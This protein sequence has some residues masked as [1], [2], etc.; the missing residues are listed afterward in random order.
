MK[1]L[2][3]TGTNEVTYREE[4]TPEPAA[5]DAKIR[6]EA[7]GI[8]GS[9]MHAYHGEDA[10]RVPPLILGHEAAGVVVSGK[11]AGQQVVLNPLISCGICLD[12]Q[13]GRS[14]LC[15]DRRLIG[16]NYPGA[17][18]EF[19]T[20]PEKNLIALPEGMNPV[21]AA[22]TEPAATSLHA[23]HLAERALHRPIADGRSLVI[24]G[25]SV[26]LLAA[27]LL[28]S[29]GCSEIMLCDTNPLRRETAFQTGCCE[30]FDP[31]QDTEKIE[32]SFELVIDAV[33]M[34]TTRQMAVRAVKSGGVMLHIGLQQGS[35]D[36]DFR[37]I[38]L[39]EMTVIGTYTYTHTDLQAAL[40]SLYRGKLGDLAWVEERPL[41]EG[42]SAFFDL[43]IG[44]TAAPK[45]V[46]LPGE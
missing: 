22:L 15:A 13:S 8:C 38:T 16:M 46:L 20:I 37:K 18:A 23:L 5:G 44:S 11:N 14:N 25:G 10:R 45:I 21:H 39:S 19:I 2:V 27:L 29:H 24:G 34:E 36:C 17:F 7:V 33:G 3:Y 41:S 32:S 28:R 35:G 40:Q 1:A 26:G 30:V 4:P 12:C 9:D 43:D 42:S 6:I 31:D